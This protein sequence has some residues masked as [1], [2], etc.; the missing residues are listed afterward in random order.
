[1]RSRAAWKAVGTSPVAMSAGL[2]S[3]RPVTSPRVSGAGG[4][5]RAWVRARRPRWLLAST[6]DEDDGGRDDDGEDECPAAKEA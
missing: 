4:G 3:V 5:V 6:G 1:M 2:A